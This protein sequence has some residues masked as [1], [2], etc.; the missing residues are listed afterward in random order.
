MTLI[1]TLPEGYRDLAKQGKISFDT[2]EILCRAA[3]A[4]GWSHRKPEKPISTSG[5][6]TPRYNDF[7]EACPFLVKPRTDRMSLDRLLLLAL[8]VRIFIGFDFAPLITVPFIAA[9]GE[10]S[11]RIFVYT[12]FTRAEKEAVIWAA[13]SAIEA[14]HTQDPALT[15]PHARFLVAELRNRHPDVKDSEL[16]ISILKKFA[17]EPQ[18][19]RLCDINRALA[20]VDA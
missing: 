8:I 6:T 1:E 7:W 15:S 5:P 18:R 12:P 19:K 16:L 2:I 3:H 13:V 9:R 20:S 14:W 10:L 11:R 17:G 4:C